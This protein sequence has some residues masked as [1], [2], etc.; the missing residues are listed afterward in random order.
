M[1][2]PKGVRSGTNQNRTAL[3]KYIESHPGATKDTIIKAVDITIHQLNNLFMNLKCE[4]QTVLINK[5]GTYYIKKGDE[6][7]DNIRGSSLPKGARLVQVEK[8]MGK[9]KADL[10]KSSHGGIHSGLNF[11]SF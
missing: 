1:P 8:R 6:P 2:A 7:N 3:L 9:H 5:R 11:D 4:I 10:R